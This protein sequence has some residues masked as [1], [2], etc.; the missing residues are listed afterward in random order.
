MCGHRTQVPILNG[1]PKKSSLEGPQKIVIPRPRAEES[2]F[3]S[4]TQA[5][6]SLPP[7]HREAGKVRIGRTKNK[8]SLA[9]SQGFFE[10]RS[11]YG[12]VVVVVVVPL[13][14]EA[15]FLNKAA[16]EAHKRGKFEQM[17]LI[18]ELFDH[19]DLECDYFFTYA[20]TKIFGV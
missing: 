1:A 9:T 14:S 20:K 5:D 2:V 4:L 16:M 15:Q 18:V 7:S 12:V 17:E 11:N 13:S 3:C 19:D 10:D 8:K 6:S